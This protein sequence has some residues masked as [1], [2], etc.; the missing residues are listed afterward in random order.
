M[1]V[2]CW[3]IRPQNSCSNIKVK[4]IDREEENF[5]IKKENWPDACF[6]SMNIY[7]PFKHWP[8]IAGHQ[9]VCFRPLGNDEED[10]ING[11]N[12]YFFCFFNFP[13]YFLPSKN[14]G[15]VKQQKI[16]Q[17]IFFIIQH[18]KIGQKNMCKKKA[19]ITKNIDII[20][21]NIDIIT[22]LL[23][24]CNLFQFNFCYLVVCFETKIFFF[25]FKLL[26]LK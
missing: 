7:W 24:G 11:W 22:V 18:N 17:L 6:H 2:R 14:F 5:R 20:I 1:G 12:I 9:S 8:D 13:E 10:D 16:Y 21:K 3:N 4:E 26:V 25:S 19:N 23:L 15:T